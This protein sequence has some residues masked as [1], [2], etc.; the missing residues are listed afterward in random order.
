MKQASKGLFLFALGGR[1]LFDVHIKQLH[2]TFS[3]TEY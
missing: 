2:K 1:G 3:I